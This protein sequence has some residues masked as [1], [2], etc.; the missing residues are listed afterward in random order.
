MRSRAPAG[1]KAPSPSAAVSA[2]SRACHSWQRPRLEVLE[3]N[4][5]VSARFRVALHPGEIRARQKIEAVAQRTE[6]VVL[7]ARQNAPRFQAFECRRERLLRIGRRDAD[8]R[9]VDPSEPCRRTS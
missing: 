1:A 9:E 8:D 4:K 3:Q 6:E 5:L 7:V 2:Q